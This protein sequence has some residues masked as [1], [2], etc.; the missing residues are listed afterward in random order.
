MYQLHVHCARVHATQYE[1]TSTHR[2]EVGTSSWPHV[3]G[4]VP[5]GARAHHS[6]ADP[7]CRRCTRDVWAPRGHAWSVLPRLTPSTPAWRDRSAR[8]ICEI[9]ACHSL[10]CNAEAPHATIPCRGDDIPP[11]HLAIYF[12][13]A[14]ARQM[15]WAQVSMKRARFHSYLVTI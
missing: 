12:L 3:Y 8:S 5:R 4:Q 7:K 9:Y 2:I 10:A 11:V 1:R 6:K 13:R 14:P 15:S